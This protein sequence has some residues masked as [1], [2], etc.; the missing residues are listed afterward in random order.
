MLWR[1]KNR[2]EYIQIFFTPEEAGKYEEYSEG[3]EI[4]ITEET[5]SEFSGMVYINTQN[6]YCKV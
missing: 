3:V 6:N 2:W 5:N 1:I 4:L